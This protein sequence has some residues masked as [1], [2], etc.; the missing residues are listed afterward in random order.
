[1]TDPEH[2]A[3]EERDKAAAA[4]GCEWVEQ[5]TRDV[6]EKTIRC[7]SCDHEWK[8]TPRAVAKGY[9]CPK[10]NAQVNL[11]IGVTCGDCGHKWTATPEDLKQGKGCPKC[12]AA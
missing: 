6:T 2:T 11:K 10:C 1:M 5:P 8:T 3:Q 12:R 4:I 7:Q 9:G